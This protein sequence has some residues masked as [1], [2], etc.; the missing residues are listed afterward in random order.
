M[1]VHIALQDC[2]HVIAVVIVNH[3]IGCI[4]TNTDDVNYTN[5]NIKTNKHKPHDTKIKKRTLHIKDNQIAKNSTLFNALCTATS[6]NET[7]IP[8]HTA[9]E[10]EKNLNDS[11]TTIR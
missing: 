6:R 4:C 9:A 10:V 7:L 1:K 8:W 2:K 3:T 11:M 5:K